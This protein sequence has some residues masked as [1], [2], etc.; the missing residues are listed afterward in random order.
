M[1]VQLKVKVADN[2]GALVRGVPQLADRT[3]RR[4]AETLLAA[5]RQ[6]APVDTGKL[7]DSHTVEGGGGEYAVV[8]DT[9]Y[10]VY[11][12][13]GTRYQA[14]NPWL[15][16]AAEHANSRIMTEIRDDLADGIARYEAHAL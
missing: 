15:A 1:R 8:A 14:A 5:A 9:P 11:V 16:R 7:R 3:A 4:G 2:M 10:A 6:E 13:W 12:H